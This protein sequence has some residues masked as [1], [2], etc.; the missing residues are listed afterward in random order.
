M[1]LLFTGGLGGAWAGA[2]TPTGA[3]T[4]VVSRSFTGG[5]T[6]SGLRWNSVY[7]IPDA[8]GTI[9]PAGALTRLVQKPLVGATTPT[10]VTVVATLRGG[11]FQTDMNIGLAF[12]VATAGTWQSDEDVVVLTAVSSRDGLLQTDE[13]MRAQ[14]PIPVSSY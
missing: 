5:V 14:V 3:L 9:T 4:K 6:S 12:V 8:A 11:A 10:G 1:I 7:V 13:N 2:V